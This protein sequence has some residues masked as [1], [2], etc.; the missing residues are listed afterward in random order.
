MPNIKVRLEAGT[1]LAGD[2]K[3]LQEQPNK[4]VSVQKVA[5][6]GVFANLAISQAKKVGQFAV[7][8]VGNFTGDYVLQRN[9]QQGMAIVGDLSSIAVGALAGGWVGAIVAT[10]G[11][12][13]GNTLE[14]VGIAQ[15]IKKE[16]YQSNFIKERGGDVYNDGSRGTYD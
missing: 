12:V 9:I 2:G 15:N 3:E 11:I 10:A 14:A 1:E 8:N 13:V 7:S 4:G 6:V 16:N 5:S